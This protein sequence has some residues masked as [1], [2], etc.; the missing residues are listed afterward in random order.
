MGPSNAVK[1]W[2]GKGARVLDPC[3]CLSLVRT[4]TL[5]TQDSRTD[6]TMSVTSQSYSRFSSILSMGLR[7][8]VSLKCICH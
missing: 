5:V 3:A 6:L 7:C 8:I 4:L 1:P 2:L